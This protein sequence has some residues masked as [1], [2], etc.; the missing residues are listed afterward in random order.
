MLEKKRIERKIH[1]GRGVL[2]LQMYYKGINCKKYIKIIRNPLN[3]CTCLRDHFYKKIL[4]F[5]NVFSIV[6]QNFKL[7]TE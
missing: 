6:L 4:S 3:K 2:T 5:F 7:R 1:K